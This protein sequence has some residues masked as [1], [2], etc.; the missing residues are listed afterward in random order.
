M[1]RFWSKVIRGKPNECWPWISGTNQNYGVF[2]FKGRNR[3]AT[4]V[5]WELTKGEPFPSGKIACHSCDNPPCVNPRHIWPGT[6]KE[7]I[8]DAARKGR[9]KMPHTKPGF[10]PWQYR[11]TKCKAGHS[12][13]GENLRI[14]VRA[15]GW[16]RRICLAC[17]RKHN[18][19]HEARKKALAQDAETKS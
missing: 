8:Q 14:A 17:Q 10:K 7:N 5:A 18:L 16:T 4:H 9:L 6:R 3:R 11:L 15:Q 2:Y 1:K 12:L 19:A 13:S